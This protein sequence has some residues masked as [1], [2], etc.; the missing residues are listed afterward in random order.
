M[1]PEIVAP[2]RHLRPVCDLPKPSSEARVPPPVIVPEH[3]RRRDVP[4]C[5]EQCADGGVAQW[6]HPWAGG[7]GLGQPDLAA[8]DRHLRPFE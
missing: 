8:L 3:I 6:Y 2:E 5:A 4:G 7:L 1:V